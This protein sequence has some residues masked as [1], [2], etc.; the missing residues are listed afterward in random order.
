M[1][2]Q[3]P[4]PRGEY[5]NPAGRGRK[6][7]AGLT[8]LEVVVSLAIFLFSITAITQLLTMSSD[9]VIE[10]NRRTQAGLMCQSKM[11]EIVAGAV[12]LDSTGYAPF[13]EN[14]D[15]QWRV[16]CEPNEVTGLWHVQVWVKKEGQGRGAAEVCLSQLIFNPPQ[17]GSTLDAAP[18]GNSGG[19]N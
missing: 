7:R 1:R 3:S 12:T 5:S 18:S 14:P 10:A 6:S 4:T 8:L 2:R 17:R 15:W 19:G 13:D 9:N 16:D 11:A